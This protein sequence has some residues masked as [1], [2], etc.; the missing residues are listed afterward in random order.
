MA[1]EK[2][3]PTYGTDDMSIPIATAVVAMPVVGNRGHH[4]TA[5]AVTSHSF[6]GGGTG[7][8]KSEAGG[9]GHG[10]GVQEIDHYHREIDAILAISDLNTSFNLFQTKIRDIGSDGGG[11]YGLIGL[12]IAPDEMH[13]ARWNVFF[14]T[15]EKDISFLDYLLQVLR[16]TPASNSEN[17]L[18]VRDKF[19]FTLFHRA[20]E[21][22]L[23]PHLRALADAGA[24]R[25]AEVVLE[26]AEG[27]HSNA[28]TLAKR[29]N[30]KS[31]VHFLRKDLG[32]EDLRS[33]TCSLM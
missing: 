16:Q 24:N 2:S 15:L 9:D 26:G 25:Q 10:Y 28:I 8:T 14:K 27:A 20:A 31:V 3:P 19:G 5:D 21:K 22:A 12:L 1:T 7:T 4:I 23:V 17:A 29:K 6:P 18:E 11:A 13:G 32:V 33:G 30:N